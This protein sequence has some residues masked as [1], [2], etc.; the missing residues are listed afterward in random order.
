MTAEDFDKNIFV[1]C[2]IINFFDWPLEI[3]HLSLGFRNWQ[4]HYSNAEEKKP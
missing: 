3:K 1:I 2:L 4:T